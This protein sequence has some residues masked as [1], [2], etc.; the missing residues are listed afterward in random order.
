MGNDIMQIKHRPADVYE[1]ASNGDAMLD[2][3]TEAALDETILSEEALQDS[4]PELPTAEAF[5]NNA[6]AF[7]S[8]RSDRLELLDRLR[9]MVMPEV[10]Q[11]SPFP[12][13]PTTSDFQTE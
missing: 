9:A 8:E 7:L 1:M 10:I 5:L 2:A 12:P 4:S 11:T 6:A 3:L 13:A